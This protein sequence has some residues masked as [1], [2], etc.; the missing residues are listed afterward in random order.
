MLQNEYISLVAS[1][2]SLMSTAVLFSRAV[3][4]NKYLQDEAPLVLLCLTVLVNIISIFKSIWN[5]CL[6]RRIKEILGVNLFFSSRFG[7]Y[8]S[9]VLLE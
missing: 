8:F 6:D 7:L 2:C 1:L 3:L 9:S 4:K 5:I